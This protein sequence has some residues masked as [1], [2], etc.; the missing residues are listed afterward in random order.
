MLGVP[1]GFP[2]LS[3]LSLP[4]LVDAMTSNPFTSSG[5]L[6]TSV[7]AAVNGL[8]VSTHLAVTNPNA[9]IDHFANDSQAF[10]THLQTSV[11]NAETTLTNAAMTG[12]SAP[13]SDG[14]LGRLLRSHSQRM[15]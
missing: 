11:S 6:A 13:L 5:N 15:T 14:Q 12:V 8:T 2:S 4:H 3:G 1:T 7:T 9:L 10:T